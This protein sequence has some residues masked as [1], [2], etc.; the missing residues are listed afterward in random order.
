MAGEKVATRP[1]I[2]LGAAMNVVLGSVDAVKI[3]AGFGVAQ[4]VALA[5]VSVW[6]ERPIVFLHPWITGIDFKDFYIAALDYVGGLDPYLRERFNKPPLGALFVFPFLGIGLFDAARTF[7]LFNAASVVSA[8]WIVCRALRARAFAQLMI[9]CATSLPVYFLLDR[10]NLDGLV[11]LLVASAAMGISEAGLGAALWAAAAL[12][13]YPL[14]LVLPFIAM[15]RW[16][17]LLCFAVCTAVSL[18]AFLPLWLGF[19]HS[20]GARAA[21]QVGPENYSPMWLLISGVDM[22]TAQH[23]SAVMIGTAGGLLLYMT[24]LGTALVIDFVSPPKTRETTLLGVL[25]Y[26]PFLAAAPLTVYP[27]VTVVL[28]LLIPAHTWSRS[29]QPVWTNAIF[30]LAMALIGIQALAW[31]SLTGLQWLDF[32]PAL[33]IILVTIWSVATKWQL[34]HAS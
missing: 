13:F 16:R 20:L 23:A 18:A 30:V 12:K 25:L 33:G 2:L 19:F 4:M 3:L 26:T 8:L 9:V 27:Y 21:L 31:S 32:L 7:F 34:R 14:L 6:S 22:L 17:A 11:M 24:A 1:P 28:L 29:R 15:R 10:G 5:I